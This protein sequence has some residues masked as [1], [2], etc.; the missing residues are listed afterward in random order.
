MDNKI[1]KFNPETLQPFDKI[2]ARLSERGIWYCELFS[3]VEKDGI[4]LIK[5]I[6]AYYRHCIPY[7]NDTK[8]LLG[9]TDEPPKYYRYWEDED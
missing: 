7:N 1:V 9:S 5:G 8:H 3:F 4:N 2:L 6:G